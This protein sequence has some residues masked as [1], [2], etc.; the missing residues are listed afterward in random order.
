MFISFISYVNRAIHTHSFSREKTSTLVKSD[1]S[2]RVETCAVLAQLAT[3]RRRLCRIAH[4]A[5]RTETFMCRREGRTKS[6]FKGAEDS[7][8]LPSGYP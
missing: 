8:P 4:S 7:G 1:V 2:T 3:G 6:G 5:A